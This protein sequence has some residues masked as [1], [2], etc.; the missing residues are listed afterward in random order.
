M[1]P[2]PAWFLLSPASD[3]L[4]MTENEDDPVD[5]VLAVLTEYE[6]KLRELQQND[7]LEGEAQQTFESLVTELERRTSGE[8]RETAREG[9]DR[10]R[11]H[12]DADLQHS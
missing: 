1:S 5:P 8:R 2:T 3:H 7:Q 12:S 11:V 4:S 6:Q 9:V 10:R